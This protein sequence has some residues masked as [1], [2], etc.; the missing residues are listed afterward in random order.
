MIV[1]RPNEAYEAVYDSGTSGLVGTIA[2]RVEDNQGNIVVPASTAG[3]IEFGTTGIY[4]SNQ[5]SPALEGQF[6]IIWSD[7]GTFAA[8]TGGVE[9]LVVTTATAGLEPLP[10]LAAD[11]SGTVGPCS[12]WTTSE[13]VA[14][15]CAADG[16]DVSVFDP[17][18]IAASELLY[19]YSGKRFA[20]TCERRVRPCSTQTCAG[21][22]RHWDGGAW[23]W[24]TY[25]GGGRV[26]MGSGCGCRALSRVPLAGFVREV[27]EVTIDGA[28][29]DP[30][31]YRV[32]ER[33]WLSRVRDPADFDTPL[34]WPACQDMDKP[35]TEDGTFSVLYTY[36]VD[37]PV[38]GQ[39][40]ARELAC[41]VYKTC[42]A[43]G[44]TSGDCPLPN[45]VVK[46]VRQN[47]TIELS[48]FAAWGQADGVWRTGMPLVDAFLNA[49]NPTGA[50][51]RASVWSPDTPRFPRPVS[52]A[53]S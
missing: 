2:V 24:A 15:C 18:V 20:G 27:L 12:A 46:I 10:P 30:N 45:G 28:I 7:T 51:R 32:D 5:I 36:G 38:A 13:D 34:Y 4:R 35:E 47:V 48:P 14:D 40:A 19:A 33:F 8:G 50:R 11:G 44:A 39:L 21:P 52:P 6:S 1:K 42:A 49:Y 25:E 17:S 43:G 16:S 3:I 9:D 41:A 31:T 53:S 26:T 22:W 23:N 37:P 29:V